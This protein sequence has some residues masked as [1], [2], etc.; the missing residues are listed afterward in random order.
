MPRKTPNRKT[1]N[2][3][4][5][6]KPNPVKVY[7]E[8]IKRIRASISTLERELAAHAEATTN[9]SATRTARRAATLIQV[10]ATLHDCTQR[11]AADRP[12]INAIFITDAF[13]TKRKATA[14]RR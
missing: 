11:L 9:A 10:V 3:N 2:D 4:A 12:G 5:T 8:Q 13:A 7:R 14:R 1:T 6:A